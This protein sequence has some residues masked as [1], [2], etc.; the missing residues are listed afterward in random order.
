MAAAEGLAADADKAAGQIGES[1]AAL[2]EKTADNEESNL[3]NTLSNEASTAQNITQ[4]SSTGEKAVEQSSAD[5]EPAADTV[6]GAG[7]PSAASTPGPGAAPEP[8]L[9]TTDPL[10]ESTAP[11][12][13]RPCGIVKPET[14]GIGQSGRIGFDCSKTIWRPGL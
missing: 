2:F 12:A 6:A 9:G 13:R 3:A 8:N 1:T 5:V 11:S 4:I 10:A 7:E 14:A